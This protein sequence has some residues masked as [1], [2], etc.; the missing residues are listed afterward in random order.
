MGIVDWYQLNQQQAPDFVS[1][2]MVK[3][4]SKITI[5]YI[6]SASKK[7]FF[8]RHTNWITQLI[9]KQKT[10]QLVIW[11]FVQFDSHIHF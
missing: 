10:Q 7:N 9:L 8:C 5:F 1:L 11:K 2:V 3:K 4:F 6:F